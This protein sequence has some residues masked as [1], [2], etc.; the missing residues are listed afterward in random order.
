M[1]HACQ[2]WISVPSVW[3]HDAARPRSL[4]ISALR[5]AASLYQHRIRDDSKLVLQSLKFSVSRPEYL[6]SVLVRSG[7]VVICTGPDNTSCAFVVAL[8]IGCRSRSSVMAS[9]FLAKASM[10]RSSLCSAL[11]SSAAL[12][13]PSDCPTGCSLGLFYFLVA[14]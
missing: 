5:T 9:V 14:M 13:S 10:S 1:I 6:G 7:V 11:S 4:E 2:A 8:V 12:F 3:C